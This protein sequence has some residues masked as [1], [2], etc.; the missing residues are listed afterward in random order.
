MSRGDGDDEAGRKEDQGQK[1]RKAA[2]WRK[3]REE[4]DRTEPS[5]PALLC[6]VYGGCFKSTRA[7][8]SETR[9]CE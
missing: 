4:V 3:E 1:T 5:Q 6:C 2:T 9:G 8:Q 7:R